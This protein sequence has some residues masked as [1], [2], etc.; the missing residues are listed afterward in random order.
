MGKS[1]LKIAKTFN[2]YPKKVSR[3]LKKIGVK[4]RGSGER[5]KGFCIDV[6]GYQICT[7]LGE[8]RNKK[9]HRI[10]MEK[11]I[12]RKLLKNEVVHHVDGNRSNNNTSNLIL[13]T[14]SEHSSLHSKLLKMKRDRFGRFEATATKS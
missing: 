2:T 5:G 10:I 11:I 1:T 14:K 3:H 8:N 13:M 9:I 6:E 12:G 4:T 7:R